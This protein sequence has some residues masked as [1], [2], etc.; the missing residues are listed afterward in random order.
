MSEQTTCDRVAANSW[1]SPSGMGVD[2]GTSY[3]AGCVFF[4]SLLVSVF[5]CLVDCF[6]LFCR[7]FF[8]IIIIFGLTYR[9][10]LGFIKKKC[11]G[12]S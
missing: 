2:F 12:G 6:I 9:A 11:L 4:L 10:F 7:C 8:I 5:F 3:L 1:E